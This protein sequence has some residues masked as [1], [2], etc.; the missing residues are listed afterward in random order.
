MFKHILIP[1]DLSDHAERAVDIAT[2]LASP[3]RSTLTLRH[4]IQTIQ[5]VEFHEM[6]S[7][8][9][10]LESRA[11]KRLAPLAAMHSHAEVGFRMEVAYGVPAT[12]ILR[13]S[14]ERTIDLVV[15]ASHT[16][17]APGGGASATRSAF[18]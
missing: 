2:E 13:I 8:Y 16:T 12:E 9:A 1:T 10:D 15:L 14:K 18:W 3:A 6:G 5:G 11:R 4:V 17:G 7:F